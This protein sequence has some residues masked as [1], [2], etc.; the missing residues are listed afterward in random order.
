MHEAPYSYTE[1]CEDFS[2]FL[3]AQAFYFIRAAC[4]MLALHLASPDAG[5]FAIYPKGLEPFLVCLST[6]G[7]VL[8]QLPKN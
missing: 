4:T 5:E 2:S 3:S 1:Y 6:P 8:P 7:S